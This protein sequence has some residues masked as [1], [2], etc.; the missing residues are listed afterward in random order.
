MP[1][2][3]GITESQVLEPAQA[4]EPL[5][6]CAGSSLSM[7]SAMPVCRVSAAPEFLGHTRCLALSAEV[8]QH[9]CVQLS[10]AAS[11]ME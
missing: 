10:S 9:V 1:D 7:S 8:L 11:E 5:P 6:A 2:S 4:A 3:A